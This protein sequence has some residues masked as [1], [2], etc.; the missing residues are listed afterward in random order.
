MIGSAADPASGRTVVTGFPFESV[1]VSQ[2]PIPTSAVEVVVFLLRLLEVKRPVIK[3]GVTTSATPLP[4][5]TFIWIGPIEPGTPVVL[6]PAMLAG[7]HTVLSK[8]A[9][10]LPLLCAMAV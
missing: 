10:K 7:V 8:P 2:I 9:V 4:L 6:P 5:E 3:E 1:I